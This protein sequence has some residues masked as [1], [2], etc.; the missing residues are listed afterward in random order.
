[1]TYDSDSQYNYFLK[2]FGSTLKVLQSLYLKYFQRI[3]FNPVKHAVDS[4]YEPS[5]SEEVLLAK[6]FSLL[7]DFATLL[8]YFAD[9]NKTSVFEI[10]SVGVKL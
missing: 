9:T 1:M 3:A 6:S 10:S 2:Y 4:N 7:N 8:K 5:C